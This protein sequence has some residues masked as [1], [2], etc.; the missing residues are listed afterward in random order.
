M[1][2][3]RI[4][5]LGATG[6]VGYHMALHL[7]QNHEVTTASRS[8]SSTDYRVDATDEGQ[9][10]RLF[11]ETK[12]E[13]VINAIKPALSTDAMEKERELTTLV[14]ARIPETLAGMSSDRGF[15]LVQISTDWVYA[16]EEGKWYDERSPVSPKNHYTETKALAE[17]KVR[18]IIPQNHLILRTEG[19]FGFDEKG[20]NIFLRLKRS[21]DGGKPV[22]LPSDQYS[23]P[24]CGIELARM[25]GALIGKGCRG[26]YNTV[27]PE[28]LSRYEFGFRVCERFGFGCALEQFSIKD[29]DIPVPAFLRIDTSK[30][31]GEIGQIK[32]LEGQFSDLEEFLNDRAQDRG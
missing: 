13:V 14:N 12:P 16:G 4:L 9:L 3:I 30:L 11:D 20:S 32:S 7:K 21:A 27:G 10:E 1:V 15:L 5:I 26:T 8:S 25:A 23:Q 31:A 19:V 24:I 6:V 28:Y 29:R 17:E 22:R 2:G 18:T